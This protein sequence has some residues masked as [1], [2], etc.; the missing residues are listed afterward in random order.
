MS[1]KREDI[2][3]VGARLKEERDR[4]KLSQEDLA[5]HL[6]I[7]GRTIKKYEANGTSMRATELLAFSG[8]GADVLY[9]VTGR[10][11]PVDLEHPSTPSLRLAAAIAALD[12]SDADADLIAAMARRL[13]S[14]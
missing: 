8:L 12:L 13:A 10:R 14:R 11:E 1:T 3:S 4:L 6:A 2:G 5:A 9:I 7:S